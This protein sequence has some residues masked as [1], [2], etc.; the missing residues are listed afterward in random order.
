MTIS[1]D[2]FAAIVRAAADLDDF[3]NR[4]TQRTLI[5]DDTLRTRGVRKSYRRHFRGRLPE[6]AN[7]LREMLTALTEIEFGSRH[8]SPLCK[9]CECGARYGSQKLEAITPPERLAFL[10]QKATDHLRADLQRTLSKASKPCLTLELNAFRLAF[11]AI[12][13]Q[14][15]E[16]AM[17]ME[18]QFLGA[19]PSD[20]LFPMFKRF[21]VLAKL[22]CQLI[23][24]WVD[25]IAELL[26]RFNIDQKTLARTFF[27]SQSIDR[28][29]DV[30][31]GLSDPH[32]NGRTVMCL[33]CQPGSIIYKPRPGYGEEDWSN[34][35]R[36][37]NSKSS[38]LK[39][40][41]AK[42]LCR[43]DYCWM[44]E[45]KFT[46][47][48]NRAAA[49]RFYERLGGTIAAA[50][51]LRAVDCHRDNLIASGEHPVLIDAE[52]L[53]HGSRKKKTQT[54]TEV[55][56]QT[57][58][59]P[60]SNVRSSWQYRSSVLGKAL[61]GRHVPRIGTDPLN[62]GAYQP[63][64]VEGFRR[65]WR[66]VVGS[67]QQQG[68]CRREFRNCGLRKLR[69][70]YW[71][72]A[73]YER[74]RRASIQPTALRSGVKRESLIGHL[75]RRN[76]CS[77]RIL[78]REIRA[79]KRFDIPYFMRYSTTFEVTDGMVALRELIGVLRAGLHF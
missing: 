57:G 24:N 9:L 58:F 73:N 43:V 52:A 67:R 3:P 66:C 33:R 7:E 32:N 79:L 39:L 61:A 15:D 70:I 2:E 14:R 69:R 30:H 20:R 37:L 41:A 8:A 21:P 74:I 6:W 56:Y 34:F 68:K 12:S 44:E 11:D 17:T 31:S 10:S 75:C 72:T 51:L 65:V 60:T 18:E 46:P 64:I 49:Q 50:C 1:E 63:E 16:Q 29:I 4:K 19:K 27:D 13:F 40:R 42:V 47:C 55:L 35:V 77:S 78:E 71:P 48:Q 25:Q 5:L 53:W 38:G 28:I 36:Y 76:R 45:I 54:L 22:W 23:S 59:F 26:L 62:P